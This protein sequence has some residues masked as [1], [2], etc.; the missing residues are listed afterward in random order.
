MAPKRK[1]AKAKAKADGGNTNGDVHVYNDYD[2]EDGVIISDD[3]VVHVCCN[4]RP[5][6]FKDRYHWWH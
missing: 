5:I 3:T 2:D 1:A 6:W 4:C